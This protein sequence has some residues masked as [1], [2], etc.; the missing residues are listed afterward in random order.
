MDMFR[1]RL[2]LLFLIVLLISIPVKGITLHENFD[3]TDEDLYALV[4]FLADTKV[5]CEESLENSLKSNCS[6][7]FDELIDLSYSQEYLD[8]SIEKSDELKNKLSYS[9][10][11]LDDLK[12]KAGSYQYLKD[13]LYP[14]QA[15]S[16]NVSY[17]VENHH[18][19]VNNFSIIVDFIKD[20][21][22]DS[23]LLLSLVDAHSSI[24]LCRN[25]L[26]SIILNLD[27]MNQSFSTGILRDLITD[28]SQI[29]DKYESYLDSLIGFLAVD[30]PT[31]LLF[32]DNEIVYLGEDVQV[33]GY[34]IADKFFIK[35]QTINV[36]W[37][38]YETNTTLTKEFGRYDT[39]LPI[40]LDV[41]PGIYNL[42]GSTVYEN[43]VYYSE[44]VLITIKKI[45]AKIT[46][47]VPKNDYYLD[48]NISFTGRLV[49]YQN[50]GIAA[51]V[52]L[53][54]SDSIFLI[55]SDENGNFAYTFDNNLSFGVYSAFAIFNPGSIYGKTQSNTVIIKI[56][57]PTVLTL[58][59]TGSTF[60]IGE[61]IELNG[62]LTSDIDNSPL[63]NKTIT[64]YL[65]DKKISD[66]K[67]NDQG[68]FFYIIETDD[69]QSGSYTIFSAYISE[70][71]EWRSSSSRIINIQIN[72]VSVSQNLI[73]YLALIIIILISIFIILF[74]R[75]K[76]L[77]KHKNKKHPKEFYFADKLD[78]PQ[79]SSE[80]VDIGDF[81]INVN[82]LNQSDF[83]YRESIISQY[84][85]LLRYLSERGMV[86]NSGI[87][88][89]DVKNRMIKEGFSKRAINVVTKN[90]EY[91][92]YSQF[93]ISKKQ[94]TTIIKKI[95]NKFCFFI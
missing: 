95:N 70:D 64:I 42:T 83:D 6:I 90:F 50:R 75:K 11:I 17:F 72:S 53:N 20:I 67:T 16:I 24:T 36:Y 2:V 32:V 84:Q 29:L 38:E 58:N 19:V 10:D 39:L 63:D 77:N 48:E 34:F 88:H 82:S 18:N 40:A 37:D 27:V 22:N 73:L 15:L 65:N 33:F 1:G 45:P 76:Q 54:V 62:R 28:L 4:E 79:V 94:D 49:D 44:K 5:L 59:I 21:G 30:E 14:I 61:E 85:I 71:L 57:T 52:L 35:N 93:P 86:F 43:N 68:L 31:L 87:T 26:N 51:E 13:F 78:I 81:S 80:K 92:M 8:L 3:E 47:S 66:T 25:N 74:F 41:N 9:S 23:N 56:N 91:A 89:L 7:S 55:L 46:L 60:D 69:L 12:D